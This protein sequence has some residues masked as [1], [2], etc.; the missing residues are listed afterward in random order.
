MDNIK[1]E[2]N[3]LK[4]TNVYGEEKHKLI[5]GTTGSRDTCAVIQIGKDNYEKISKLMAQEFDTMMVVD[6]LEKESK[7][8]KEKIE[9]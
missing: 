7:K 5:V 4:D 6:S 2:V 9:K 8:N 3:V 1:L